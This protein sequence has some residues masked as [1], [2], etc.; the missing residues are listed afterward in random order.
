MLGAPDTVLALSHLRSNPAL[1]S[2]AVT[3][4]I[5]NHEDYLGLQAVSHSCPKLERLSIDVRGFN[6]LPLPAWR[7]SSG[8][9]LQLKALRIAGACS[10]IADATD[11]AAIV[12]PSKLRSISI[13]NICPVPTLLSFTNLRSLK[14]AFI[15]E[16][17]ALDE[18]QVD[19]R[20]ELDRLTQFLYHCNFLET[21]DLIGA[22]SCIDNKLLKHLGPSLRHLRLHEYESAA[23]VQRR[24]VLSQQQVKS[25]GVLCPKLVQLGLDLE[26]KDEWVCRS[27]IDS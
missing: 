23:G 16:Q 2:L 10:G 22:T 13:C 4:S 7:S 21:L 1:T 9:G 17:F 20:S 15:E 12:M 3:L 5:F 18:H 19:H 25:L 14:I 27:C 8:E 11:M 26:Y 6:D 24:Q